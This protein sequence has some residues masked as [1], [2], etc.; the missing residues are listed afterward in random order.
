MI[1]VFRMDASDHTSMLNAEEN[2]R[3]SPFYCFVDETLGATFISY[4]VAKKLSS[5]FEK[6]S[7]I[8]MLH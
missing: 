8:Q 3:N 1:R 6:R 5:N 4:S 2:T 7:Y